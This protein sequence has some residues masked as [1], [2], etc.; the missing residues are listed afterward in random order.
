MNRLEFSWFADF[1]VRII[2]TREEDGFLKNSPVEGTVN[3]MERLKSF[4]KLMSKN[5]ISGY[6]TFL[7]AGIR[8]SNFVSLTGSFSPDA[9]FQVL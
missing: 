8:I 6:L 9:I 1:F 4:V 5:S 2:K 7:S 3:S